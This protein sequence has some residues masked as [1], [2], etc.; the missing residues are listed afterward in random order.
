MSPASE[1]LKT[2][3]A[4]VVSRV[5]FRDVNRAIDDSFRNMLRRVLIATCAAIVIVVALFETYDW[6]VFR[7]RRS[8]FLPVGNHFPRGNEC[9]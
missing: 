5:A 6:L 8:A 7:P 3:E 9:F 2:T 4:A 1:M